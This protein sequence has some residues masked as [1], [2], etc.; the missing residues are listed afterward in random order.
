MHLTLPPHKFRRTQN[1]RTAENTYSYHTP[2]HITCYIGNARSSYNSNPPLACATLGRPTQKTLFRSVQTARLYRRR[3]NSITCMHVYPYLVPVYL[4]ALF[5]IFLFFFIRVCDDLNNNCGCNY[6][7]GDCCGAEVD[8]SQCR[9]CECKDPA[10]STCKEL[11]VYG[12]NRN[13]AT[14]SATALSNL[15]HIF[16]CSSWGL[17]LQDAFGATR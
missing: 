2:S 3:V 14:V 4:C 12:R 6:D 5:F 16:F 13:L 8:K 17:L 15:S 10:Y 11:P 7:A 9:F 1:N